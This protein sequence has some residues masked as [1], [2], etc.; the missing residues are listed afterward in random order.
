MTS[1]SPNVDSSR[2][3]ERFHLTLAAGGI[4]TSAL[5]G[6]PAFTAAYALGAGLEVVNFRALCACTTR[7]LSGQLGGSRPWV[8]LLGMRLAM[9]FAAMGV[10]LVAGAHPLGLLLGVSTVVPALLVGAWWLGPPLDPDAPAL[11][12]DDPA[13]EHWSVWRADVLP[14]PADEEDPA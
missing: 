8:A 6:G 13:W 14:P 4:A 11:P 5:L 2:V 12:P 10:A 9:L 1:L 3:L 7:L